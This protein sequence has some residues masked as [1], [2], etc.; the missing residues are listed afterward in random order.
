V[1]DSAAASSD[2]PGPDRLP[3][4]VSLGRRLREAR[5]ARG[6]ALP[7]L[8]EQ[9]FLSPDR[10]EALETGDHTRLPE[11]I[12]L[13]A[14][15]RRVARSLGLDA[16]ALVDPL[17]DLELPGNPRQPARPGFSAPPQPA[18]AAAATVAP[19]PPAAHA[20]EGS[21]AGG[22]RAGRATGIALALV[23]VAGLAWG[24]QQLS[25][26]RA[27]APTAGK[28]RSGSGSQGAGAAV[29][30]GTL[31]LSGEQPSWLEVRDGSGKSL[32][33]GLFNGKARF[34]LERGLEVLAGRPDL[35][36]AR[37]GSGP[38]EALGRIEQVRWESFGPTGQRLGAAEP[39]RLRD[40]P[41]GAGTEPASQP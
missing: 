33:R 4:L 31:E 38:A 7:V 36:Q 34:S 8:A 16:D 35:V 25:P 14:Q 1:I 39:E 6:I 13:L 26:G 41:A 37:V 15:A 10:L 21:M 9:N 40:E 19:Q 5:E 24:W 17:V 18:P 12:Y 20:R 27:P 29:P 22:L 3:E 2:P 30:A 11:R 23:A 28:A 32:F